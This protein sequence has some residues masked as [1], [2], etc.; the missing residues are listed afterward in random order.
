MD[1]N[2]D[3][4]M[5]RFMLWLIPILDRLLTRLKERYGII[6]EDLMPP[7]FYESSRMYE[8]ARRRKI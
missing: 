2:R 4:V 1:R 6:N 7:P 5:R 3:R 8:E